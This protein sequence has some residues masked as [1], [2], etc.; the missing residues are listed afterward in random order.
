MIFLTPMTNNMCIEVRY[1]NTGCGGS[2]SVNSGRKFLTRTDVDR[3]LHV[4]FPVMIARFIKTNECNDRILTEPKH[5]YK[6]YNNIYH[7]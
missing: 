5:I 4:F 2:M 3:D 6:F 7:Q 1:N